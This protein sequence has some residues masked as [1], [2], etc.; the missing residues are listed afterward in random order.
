MKK[1]FTF[2]IAL[3]FCFLNSAQQTVEE[4]D[5]ESEKAAVKKFSG[6]NF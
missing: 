5:I 4:L 3:S 2:L 1:I 6:S